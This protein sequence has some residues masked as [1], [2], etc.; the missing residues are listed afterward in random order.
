MH[1]EQ[2]LLSLYRKAFNQQIS[3]STASNY[4]RLKTPLA[5]AGLDG[6]FKKIPAEKVMSNRTLLPESIKV[7][8]TK[9]LCEA[10]CMENLMDNSVQRSH[11]SLSYRS[12]F[13]TKASPPLENLDKS[14]RSCHS[15]PLSFMQV[16]KYFQSELSL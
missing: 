16:I 8:E 15:Q 13:P 7:V 2:Y 9:K 12:K 3:V 14:L 1:L 6:T 10:R 11:S 4:S 5:E